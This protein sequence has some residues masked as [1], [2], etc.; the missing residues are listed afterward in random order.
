MLHNMART[1]RQRRGAQAED[2]AATYLTRLGWQVLARN[3]RVGRDEIDLLAVDPA[4]P[5]ELVAV[6]VRSATTA[7]FGAPEER[8]DRAKV[9]HLYRGLSAAASALSGFPRAVGLLPRRVDLVLVDRRQGRT[10]F[11]HV[12]GLEPPG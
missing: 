9:A 5:P 6:E 11:R 2:L 7:A 8:I 4:P 10:E 1:Q 12:R 3:V